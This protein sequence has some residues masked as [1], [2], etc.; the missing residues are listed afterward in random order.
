MEQKQTGSKLLSIELGRFK[1]GK[2]FITPG[3]RDAVSI[4][5]VETL[6]QRHASCDWGDCCEEDWDSNVTALYEGTRIFSV[7]TANGGEKVWM[8][9]EAD[10]SSTTLLLPME[11]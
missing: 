2:L 3:A 10:R 11:Y 4:E 1:L 7:Y 5:E 9:T 6:L 8:I